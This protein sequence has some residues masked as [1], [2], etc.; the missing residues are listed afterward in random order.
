MKTRSHGIIFLLICPV[1]AILSAHMTS[2]GDEFPLFFGIVLLVSIFVLAIMGICNITSHYNAKV[3]Y[4]V[5][6]ALSIVLF[7]SAL[8]LFFG[9]FESSALC[10][11]LTGASAVVIL[12]LSHADYEESNRQATQKQEA[13]QNGITIQEG[14]TQPSKPSTEYEKPK[15]NPYGELYGKIYEHIYSSVGYICENGT[16]KLEISTYCIFL[17]DILSF[18]T[19]HDRNFIQ[20]SVLQYIKSN[21]RDLFDSSI[22]LYD[23]RTTLYSKVF[24]RQIRAFG[25]WK[26]GDDP[27]IEEDPVY[28]SFITLCDILWNP[29]CVQDYENAPLMLCD[30]QIDI[31]FNEKVKQ[32]Y[33]SILEEI[34]KSGLF[35]RPTMKP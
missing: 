4:P 10:A 13:H 8:I 34:N 5:S 12:L 7:V 30:L 18:I 25:A 1:L 15:A 23:V 3:C 21:Y 29:D 16:A 9:E 26:L 14:H 31:S 19:K 22:K 17:F 33:I 20:K 24:N 28:A 32:A 6:L 27:L 35:R 2:D 11:L